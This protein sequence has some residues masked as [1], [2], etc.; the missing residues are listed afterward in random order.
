MVI[1]ILDDEKLR[2]PKTKRYPERPDFS[3]FLQGVRVLAWALT[4]S[5]GGPEHVGARDLEAKA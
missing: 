2:S 5:G 3:I 1:F 4:H